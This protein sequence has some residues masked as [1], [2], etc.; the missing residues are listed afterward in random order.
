MKL[1]VV[2]VY[3]RVAEAYS[4]PQF[5]PSLGGYVRAFMDEINR[6]DANNPLF[7]HPVDFELHQLGEFDDATGS[8][9]EV[10]SVLARG[11]DHAQVVVPAVVSSPTA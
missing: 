4:Q 10:R 8:F 5:G 7:A 11:S 9:T 1:K 3:D 2:S 6:N